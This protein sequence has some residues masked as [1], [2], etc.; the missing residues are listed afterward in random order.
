MFKFILGVIVG[1]I[2]G[3]I[4]A[5]KKAEKIQ[6]TEEKTEAASV[7][8]TPDQNAKQGDVL[9]IDVSST[10]ISS[11]EDTVEVVADKYVALYQYFK[12]ISAEESEI[13]LTFDEIREIIGSR[14][15]LGARREMSW[16]NNEKDNKNCPNSVWLDAGFV[17][18][19][20]NIEGEKVT[21]NRA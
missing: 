3:G 16:W 2:L 1:F 7:P 8:V 12:K 17:F 18:S 4:A 19:A 9:A 6:E 20:V 11:T 15:P 14:L 10:V 21:F 13:Q 5:T